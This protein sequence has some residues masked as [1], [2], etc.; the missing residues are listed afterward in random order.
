DPEAVLR[1]VAGKVARWFRLWESQGF[2]PVRE[3]WLAGNGTLGR[4]LLLPEGYGH[5]QATA[6]G[7]DETG[8][9][10]A[11][12]DDGALLRIDSGEILLS[13]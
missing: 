7:M 9:L 5:S 12:A 11:R 4:K 1:A 13:G 6:V 8:A 3:A 2:S 10:L